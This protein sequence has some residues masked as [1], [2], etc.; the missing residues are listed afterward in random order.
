MEG[1]C[2]KQLMLII[3]A[4]C[5][6]VKCLTRVSSMLINL[7]PCKGL[8][9]C[10]LIVGFVSFIRVLVEL[11]LSAMRSKSFLSTDLDKVGMIYDRAYGKMHL[12]HVC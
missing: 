1:S 12:I 9:S 6:H 8:L 3:A 5:S 11:S 2:L 7:T 4:N 10:L